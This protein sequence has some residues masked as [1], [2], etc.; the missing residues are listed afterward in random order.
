[1]KVVTRKIGPFYAVTGIWL[2]KKEVQK[3]LNGEDVAL[4]V[5]SPL[6]LFHQDI[7]VHMHEVG[8]D[9]GIE[10]EGMREGR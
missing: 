3:L 1:M 9:T 8:K 4:K 10:V 2:C 7:T 5:T 6:G